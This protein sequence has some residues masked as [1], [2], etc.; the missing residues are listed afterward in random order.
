M[1]KGLLGVLF[2]YADKYRIREAIALCLEVENQDFIQ[3]E[4]VGIQQ[5]E[6]VV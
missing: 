3:N 1:L 2:L 4:F 6:V 5:I